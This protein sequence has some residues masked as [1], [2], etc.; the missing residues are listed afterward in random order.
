MRVC[1][2]PD[3][4]HPE[5]SVH[6]SGRRPDAEVGGLGRPALRS[7]QVHVETLL[8]G[9]TSLPAGLPQEPGTFNTEQPPS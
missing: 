1:A 8:Q 3:L 5:G 6:G 9:A 7:L 4:W 2:L